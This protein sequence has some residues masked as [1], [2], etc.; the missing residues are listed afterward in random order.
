MLQRTNE[1]L[2]LRQIRPLWSKPRNR[3][4]RNALFV[5]INMR[6]VCLLIQIVANGVL[7]VCTNIAGIFT[8]YPCEVAQRQAFIET[9]QCIEARIS[10]QREN[11]QQVQHEC[12]HAIDDLLLLFF[13]WKTCKLKCKKVN[14][15]NSGVLRMQ[16][17]VHRIL[18]KFLLLFRTRR[19][20]HFY[21][22]IYV[23]YTFF[24]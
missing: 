3:I 2:L 22:R 21:E 24:I 5:D 19:C 15:Q 18:G 10:I 16:T 4:L 12:I 17:L 23:L 7:Y 13:I 9:R 11:Q 20:L 14:S 1:M 8:H 6:H